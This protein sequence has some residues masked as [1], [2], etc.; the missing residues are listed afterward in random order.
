MCRST[1]RNKNLIF[2]A[3]SLFLFFKFLYKYR[4][5]FDCYLFIVSHIC[6]KFLLNCHPESNVAKYRT[7]KELLFV[8]S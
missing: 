1:A 2:N 7:R 5:G 3:I 8:L 4:N 6:M